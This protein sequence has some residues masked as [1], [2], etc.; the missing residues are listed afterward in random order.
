MPRP[1]RWLPGSRQFA[2]IKAILLVLCLVPLARLVYGAVGNTLGANP[3]EAIT[4]STGWWALTFLMLTLSVTPLRKLTGANWLLRLRRLER[5]PIP[6]AVLLAI[7]GNPAAQIS[8]I[9]NVETVFR[10]GYGFDSAK[11]I[12]AVRGLVGVR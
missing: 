3:I 7:N 4:R 11:M 1:I 10:D 8:D 2:W 6:R 12:E 9:K 5:G